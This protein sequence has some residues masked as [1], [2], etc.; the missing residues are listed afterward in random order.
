MAGAYPGRDG[1]GFVTPHM[2]L[3]WLCFSEFDD[4]W[5]LEPPQSIL[6]FECS[7]PHHNE[8]ISYLL[9]GEAENLSKDHQTSEK[10]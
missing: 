4:F 9:S 6:A 7:V 3:I 8:K 2:L 10:I 5:A 1:K